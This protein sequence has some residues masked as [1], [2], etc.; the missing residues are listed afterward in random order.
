ML[1]Q[2]W[3]PEQ[4]VLVCFQCISVSAEAKSCKKRAPASDKPFTCFMAISK[5]DRRGDQDATSAV[6]YSAELQNFFVF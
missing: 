1:L 3:I 6:F 2:P 4:V 5:A